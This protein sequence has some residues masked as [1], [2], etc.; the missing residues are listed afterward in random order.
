MKVESIQNILNQFDS[1]WGDEF[2][3]WLTKDD[4]RKAHINSIVEW[5]N[6]I[7]HGQESNTT[8]VT[9]VSVNSAFTTIVNLVN[10]I[11]NMVKK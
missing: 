6:S 8:G 10:L 9:L 1:E 4:K 7:A 5:R 3:S 2:H 11:E